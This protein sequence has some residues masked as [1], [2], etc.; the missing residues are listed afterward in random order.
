MEQRLR[1]I[2][3][4]NKW[5]L[6]DPIY[7]GKIEDLEVSCE[8]GKLC[9]TID[10]FNKGIIEVFVSTEKPIPN[11]FYTKEYI[12]NLDNTGIYYK[13]NDENSMIRISNITK[14]IFGE[15]PKTIYIRL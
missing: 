14:R 2:K 6:H 1:F 7:K 8:V 13:I 3:L 9:D 11:K 4:A 12:L 10:N 5:F 15:F